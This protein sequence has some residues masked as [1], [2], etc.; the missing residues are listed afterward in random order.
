MSIASYFSVCPRVTRE[1]IYFPPTSFW[2]PPVPLDAVAPVSLMSVSAWNICSEWALCNSR[3]SMVWMSGSNLLEGK[4]MC[5]EEK[6]RRHS[7]YS[8]F[9]FFFS[10]WRKCYLLI[11]STVLCRISQLP[12]IY[13]HDIFLE[14]HPNA[15]LYINFMVW[16]LPVLS[17]SKADEWKKTHNIIF[18]SIW[19]RLGA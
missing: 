14:S 4:D 7:I 12:C 3:R 5:V 11:S 15:L 9:I 19:D 13:F 6:G 1:E 18:K 16:F 10:Y 2:V 17:F 8:L